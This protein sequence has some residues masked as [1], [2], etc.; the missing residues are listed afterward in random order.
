MNDPIAIAER[1]ARRFGDGAA[2][3]NALHDAS[4]VIHRGDRIAL[5][6]PSGSGKSTFLHLLGGLDLPTSGTIAWPALG[7][8]DELRPTQVVNVFQGPSLLAPLS[9]IDNV[10][11]PLVL[12]GQDARAATAAADAA[13]DAFDVIALR[14]KLPEEI[15]GG[16]AQRVAI[17]RAI[18]IRPAFILAD[19]PTGQL[20][21]TTG[22]SVLKTLLRLAEEWGIA[23]VV[24]THDSRVAE[25][26]AVVW[27]MREGRLTTGPNPASSPFAANLPL[28]TFGPATA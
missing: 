18:A 6:G 27:V 4:C 8:I 14:D 15:S 3:M 21:S 26:F 2:A 12:S 13:L 23:I 24:S 17:A 25:R 20:D 19:E 1:V 7:G 22:A 11:L 16:Q 5:T 9:V 28:L 10:R